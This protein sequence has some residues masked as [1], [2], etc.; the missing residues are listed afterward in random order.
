MFLTIVDAFHVLNIL[1]MPL[2]G[3]VVPEK[4][5]FCKR[6]HKTPR[7][8]ACMILSRQVCRGRRRRGRAAGRSRR[9][10]PVWLFC[11]SRWSGRATELPDDH[12]FNHWGKKKISYYLLKHRQLAILSL[13]LL[14][15]EVREG[16]QLS[17]VTLLIS[18]SKK[19]SYCAIND[20]LRLTKYLQQKNQIENEILPVFHRDGDFSPTVAPTT[21]LSRK[22][23]TIL[24]TNPWTLRF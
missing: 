6:K 19:K 24:L 2:G 8:L 18:I 1:L 15:A 13:L 5:M 23:V 14:L 11:C 7:L 22:I 21:S 3:H 4:K 12:Y 9:R 10:P 20:N 17:L 16:V